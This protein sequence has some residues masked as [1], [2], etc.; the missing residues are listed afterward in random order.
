MLMRLLSTERKALR[1][2]HVEGDVSMGSSRPAKNIDTEI[3]HLHI[4]KD[5]YKAFQRCVWM[6]VNESG[7]NQIEIM[8]E[9]VLDFLIKHKC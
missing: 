3:L 1:M 8:N 5:L 2:I 6:Q 4:D 9:M 7:K